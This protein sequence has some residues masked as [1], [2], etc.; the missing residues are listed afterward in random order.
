M[1]H[2]LAVSFYIESS[3]FIKLHQTHWGLFSFFVLRIHTQLFRERHI[4]SNASM[5]ACL[6]H[7]SCLFV[8]L[9]VCLFKLQLCIFVFRLMVSNATVHLL[10]VSVVSLLFVLF[11]F[12]VSGCLQS[13]FVCF[14]QLL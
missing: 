11:C 12:F 2:L 4:Q 8:C 13:L 10:V 3:S 1:I 14:M 7:H 6:V 9:F 5:F